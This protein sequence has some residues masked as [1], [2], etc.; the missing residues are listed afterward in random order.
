LALTP[1]PAVLIKLRLA[2]LHAQAV[3]LLQPPMS[4]A[5]LLMPRTMLSKLLKPQVL[6]TNVSGST[7]DFRNIF[8]I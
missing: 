8:N 3:T 1:L 2:L 4:L 5:M 7:N 6:Q